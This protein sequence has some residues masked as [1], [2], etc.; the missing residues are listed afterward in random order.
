MRISKDLYDRVRHSC[1]CEQRNLQRLLISMTPRKTSFD[2]VYHS[3]CE[4]VMSSRHFPVKRTAT[5]F[6]LFRWYAVPSALQLDFTTHS[7]TVC[8]CCNRGYKKNVDQPSNLIS[9]HSL[10]K[11]KAPLPRTNCPN[12]T[13]PPGTRS[14]GDPAGDD[15]DL[16]GVG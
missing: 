16:N 15:D 2:H 1:E 6:K 7:T 10:G 4:R 12:G 11:L 9:W 13:A 3:I 5:P 14:C 8:V